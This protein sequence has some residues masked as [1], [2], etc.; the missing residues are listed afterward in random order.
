ML[1]SI[2]IFSKIPKYKKQ[3]INDS[4]KF[5]YLLL[6]QHIQVWIQTITFKSCCP[7]DVHTITITK[8]SSISPLF[9]TAVFMPNKITSGRRHITNLAKNLHNK[10]VVMHIFFLLECPYLSAGITKVMCEKILCNFFCSFV[11]FMV[12]FILRL[13]PCAFPIICLFCGPCTVHQIKRITHTKKNYLRCT[14]KR[15]IKIS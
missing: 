4:T 2:N 13:L 3:T 7:L 14:K 11:V 9:F 1:K 5:I 10:K 8:N 15:I 6:T 12:N